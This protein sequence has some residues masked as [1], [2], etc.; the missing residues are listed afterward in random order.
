MPASKRS[1]E[2]D[3]GSP[4]VPA[5]LAQEL[6]W[7]RAFPGEDRQLSVLRRWIS[8]LL[9]ECAARDD[10]ICVATELSTNAVQHTASGRGGWFIAEI[11]RYSQVVRVAVADCGAATEPQLMGDLLADHRRGL[12]LVRSLSVRTGVVGDARGRLVWAEIIWDSLDES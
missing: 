7:R 11:T 6:R 4:Q 3:T 2:Q 5:V 9:P 1:C 10:V 8:S 12:L